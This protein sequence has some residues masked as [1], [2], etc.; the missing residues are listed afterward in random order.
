MNC[1]NGT[2]LRMFNLLRTQMILVDVNCYMLK[3]SRNDVITRCTH[4]R[5]DT[6]SVKDGSFLIR[7]ILNLLMSKQD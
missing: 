5:T 1:F 6:T 2:P 7:K 4:R 3:C